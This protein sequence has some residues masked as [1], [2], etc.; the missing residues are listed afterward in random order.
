LPTARPAAGPRIRVITYNAQF[1]PGVAS[2]WNK[3]PEPQYRARTLAERLAGYDIIGLNEMFD[4]RPRELLLAEL[5][6][7]W[8]KD[9]HCVS[10]PASQASAFSIDSGLVLVSRFPIVAR[11]SLPLGNDSSIWK[12]GLLADGFAAKGVLHA[13]L[14]LADSDARR[15]LVDVFLTHLESQEPAVRDA[16]SLLLAQFIAAHA[17][18]HLP[19][20]LLGDFNTSGDP[21]EI[22][23][24]ASP[25]QRMLTALQRSR[26]SSP[27][28]DLWPRFGRGLGGTSDPEAPAG[29]NRI[30]YIFVSNPKDCPPPLRPVAVHVNPMPDRRVRTLSDHAAVEADFDWRR[31]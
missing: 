15:G 11:H 2:A 8:G 12:H 4:L 24:P 28:V 26:P 13:R 25:Y 20:L 30:D 27:W 23:N 3:R 22:D 6:R 17:D 16:Q 1:L 5:A 9:F 10:P 18:P 31:K 14:R 21:A 19:A 29:G 7:R